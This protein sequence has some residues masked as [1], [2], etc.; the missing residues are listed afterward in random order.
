[1]VE[2]KKFQTNIKVKEV[3]TVIKYKNDKNY[4]ENRPY[5]TIVEVHI[6]DINCF[7]NAGITLMW[8]LIAGLSAL[9]YAEASAQIGVGSD[10][11]EADPTQTDLQDAG[12]VWVAM[13]VDFPEVSAQK[14]TFAGTYGDGV[15]LFAW[16]ECGVRQGGAATTLINRVVTDKGTKAV[17]EVWVAKSEITIT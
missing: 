8:N 4:K 14:I 2:K 1:M 15:A 6:S 3:T 16:K 17:G 9:H 10:D 7:L 12:A 5:Q 13:D 11:T